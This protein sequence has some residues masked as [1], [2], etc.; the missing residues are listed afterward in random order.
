MPSQ[1]LANHPGQLSLAIP[2]WVGKNEYWLWLWPLLR[3]NGESCVTGGPVIKTAGILAYSRLKALAVNAA[4]HP[5]DI[6][7][8]LANW[9]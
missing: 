3:K 4:G 9:S 7:R 8:I 2:L 1:C 5:A 6:G